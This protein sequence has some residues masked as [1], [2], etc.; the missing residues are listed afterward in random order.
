MLD[1]HVGG[2]I[3]GA[4]FYI[5]AI[6]C[7]STDF[8]LCFHTPEA[9]VKVQKMAWRD[10]IIRACLYYCGFFCDSAEKWHMGTVELW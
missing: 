8:H 4:P 6:T 9:G 1:F 10:Q 2:E 5:S 3:S 7:E